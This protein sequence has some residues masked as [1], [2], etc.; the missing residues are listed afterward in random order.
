MEKFS[1]PNTNFGPIHGQG[2]SLAY[3]IL[4]TVLYL[5]WSNDDW[6]P[7]EEVGS[8]S[9]VKYIIKARTKNLSMD[10]ALDSQL[11]GFEFKTTGW[12]QGRPSLSS[13]HGQ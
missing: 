12:L 11:L 2:D 1:C 7:S 13:F 8:Q 3:Q 5:I 6:E 10:K 4:I 9:L